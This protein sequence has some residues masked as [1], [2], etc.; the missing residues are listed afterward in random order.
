MK[1]SRKL[2]QH[3]VMEMDGH[4]LFLIAPIPSGTACK[5]RDQELRGLPGSA[6]DSEQK[7]HGRRTGNS[8]HH[9]RR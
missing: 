1:I 3:P 5:F 9:G 6:Q 8:K 2:V 4:Q 7:D